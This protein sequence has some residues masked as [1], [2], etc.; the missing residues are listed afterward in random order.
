MGQNPNLTDC[1]S[2]IKVLQTGM[3][4]RENPMRMNFVTFQMQKWVSY[5]VPSDFL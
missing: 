4:Q 5:T 2:K 1:S 3:D